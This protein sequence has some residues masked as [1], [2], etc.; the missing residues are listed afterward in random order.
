MNIICKI[1][2]KQAKNFKKE[3]E[4]FPTELT[5]SKEARSV[6]D[7]GWI[8][9]PLT[10]VHPSKDPLKPT[11]V[12]APVNFLMLDLQR[13]GMIPAL[14]WQIACWFFLL[15][16]FIYSSIHPS[17]HD[18]PLY[19]I[20]SSIW[21]SVCLCPCTSMQKHGG[22]RTTC[23]SFSPLWRFLG[24]NLGLRLGGK[25]PYMMSYLTQPCLLVISDFEPLC[26]GRDK[27]TVS[28]K[29]VDGGTFEVG[30]VLSET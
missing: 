10:F 5:E 25:Y 28:W 16:L 24:F 17:I 14:G 21:S 20:C 12:L 2:Q 6:L 8:R 3:E 4:V 7:V 9:V 19:C 29:Y 15:H 22:E 23:K 27:C 11:V 1:L 26:G 18:L 13:Q 30:V